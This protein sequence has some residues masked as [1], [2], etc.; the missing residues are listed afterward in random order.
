MYS[1]LFV[2]SPTEPLRYNFRENARQFLLQYRDNVGYF[3]AGMVGFHLAEHGLSPAHEVEALQH[4]MNNFAG[5]VESAKKGEGVKS[6]RAS[7][8]KGIE[9]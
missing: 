1:V 2:N 6:M 8:L 4:I 3:K 9:G 7:A 5:A